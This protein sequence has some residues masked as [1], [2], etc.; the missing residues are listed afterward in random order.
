MWDLP[1]P[2]LEPVSP[3]LAGGF[4][5]TA[6]PGKSP[7]FTSMFRSLK[8]ETSKGTL[9]IKL[10]NWCRHFAWCDIELTPERGSSRLILWVQLWNELQESYSTFPGFLPKMTHGSGSTKGWCGKLGPLRWCLLPG[11]VCYH[12]DQLCSVPPAHPSQA[13][14]TLQKW[15]A[16][17]EGLEAR[18]YLLLHFFVKSKWG[19]CLWQKWYLFLKEIWKM[20]RDFKNLPTW[21]IFQKNRFHKHFRACILWSFLVHICLNV[22]FNF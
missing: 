14:R 4:L 2:G 18:T 10:T 13:T 20:R 17:K 22:Y 7:S 3:A 19:F 1:G 6:P 21:P 15:R 8:L 5:I 12:T 11:A 16:G 9:S